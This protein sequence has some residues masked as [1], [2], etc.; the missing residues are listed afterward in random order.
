[1]YADKSKNTLPVKFM[2]VWFFFILKL[3]GEIIHKYEREN[4]LFACRDKQKSKSLW[5]FVY[6]FKVRRMSMLGNQYDYCK[7]ECHDVAMSIMHYACVNNDIT[8]T[9]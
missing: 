4:D 8:A 1:M 7:K 5:M 3:F 2:S 6:W 9:K